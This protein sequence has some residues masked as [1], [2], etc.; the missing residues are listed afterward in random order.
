MSFAREVAD[1]VVFLSDGELIE[2]GTPEQIFD[3]PQHP[4]TVEFLA[5][6]QH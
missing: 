4:A 6:V 5:R 1:R 3:A 2:Q